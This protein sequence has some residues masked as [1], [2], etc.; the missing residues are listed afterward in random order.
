MAT[1]H[2]LSTLP[3]GLDMF[4]RADRTPE[5]RVTVNTIRLPPHAAI[6]RLATTRPL[7]QAIPP[8][9]PAAEGA[10]VAAVVPMAVVGAAAV[11]AVAAARTNKPRG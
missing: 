3:P 7:R 5:R 9:A 11:V 10:A 8:A 4:P 1:V 6:R 2:A